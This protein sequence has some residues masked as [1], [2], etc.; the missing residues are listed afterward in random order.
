M[1]KES[2]GKW[3]QTVGEGQGMNVKG[4][5]VRRTDHCGHVGI[6]SE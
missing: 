6:N 2:G 1:N 4:N 3:R 5:Q